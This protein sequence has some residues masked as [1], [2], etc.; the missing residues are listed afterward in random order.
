LRHINDEHKIY[1][2][3]KTEKKRKMNEMSAPRTNMV[4]SQILTNKVTDD[5]VTAA[6]LSVP[7]EKFVPKAM[8]GVAYVDEQVEVG[9]GRFILAPMTF[10]RMVQ[11]ADVTADDLVLDVGA[12]MGYSSAVLAAL[13]GT[14]VGLEVNE[15]LVETGNAILN[16]MEIDNAAL[17]AG[18]LA[19]GL[20]GQGPFDVIFLNGAVAAPG[21]TLLAQLNDGGRVSV[22]ERSGLVG[23]AV[24][25]Q[26][27][28]DMVAHR[29]LF[30]AQAAALPG[31][32][33]EAGFTF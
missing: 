31:F 28:G 24:I 14:V 18:D 4:N 23:E 30:D 19:E 15:E 20:N 5:R 22:V 9:G 12:A 10:A 29:V 1:S 32:E 25:Y 33:V 6:L 3:L 27:T 26:R 21:E 11:A 2:N 8:A 13:A 7:R 17:V 16:D